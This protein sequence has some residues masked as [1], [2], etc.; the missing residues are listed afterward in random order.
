MAVVN[1][2]SVLKLDVME[3]YLGESSEQPAINVVSGLPRSGTSM[4]MR[5][6]EF[7]GISPVTDN[8]KKNDSRNPYGYYELEAVKDRM[9][10]VD[11]IDSVKGKSVKIVS[12]FIS[13]LP[14]NNMYNVILINRDLDAVVQSQRDM[15]KHYSN[16]EKSSES[17][18]EMKRIYQQHIK[19]VMSWIAKR[20]NIRIIE[21]NYEE[22]LQSPEQE[23]IKLVDFLHPHTLDLKKMLNAIE[24]QL[25]HNSRIGK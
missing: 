17:D 8:V 2:M 15:A 21:L 10:Y 9:S 19:E 5:I 13:Y 3:I 11:W 7:G 14:A 12:R 16:S 6:L 24:P 22:L 20:P 1:I 25:N 23:L 18:Y 4:M